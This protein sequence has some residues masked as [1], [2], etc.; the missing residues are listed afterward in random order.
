MKNLTEV[1]SALRERYEDLRNLRPYDRRKLHVLWEENHLHRLLSAYHVDC[2]FDIGANYG[3]YA[4]MLRNKARFN[5]LIISFEPIPAAAAALRELAR[6]DPLWA[7]EELAIAG[8][9]GEQIFHIMKSSTF[10][11][12]SSASNDETTL[13]EASNSLAQA[14]TVKTE[15]L[16]TAY[17]RL[18]RAHGFKRPFLKMDTQGF[19]VRIVQAAREVLSEFIGLQSELA[20][21]KLYVDSVDFRE[22]LTI[23][24][25]NGFQLSAFVPN[26]SGHFPQ[27]IET[28]CIMVRRDLITSLG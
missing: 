6:H 28:D 21:K 19:D 22:A 4:Q 24:E 17:R 2:V 14:I 25:N 18:Q 8:D 16:A 7:V 5:G 26:N 23:Y 12:L 10:S 11:S 1:K 3:Q 20:I 27:L 9:D 15:S 13:F